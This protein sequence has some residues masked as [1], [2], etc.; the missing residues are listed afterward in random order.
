MTNTDSIS[1]KAHAILDAAETHMRRG[2]FDAVSFRDLATEVG[3]KSASV[4]YH[5]PQKGDLGEA[6]VHRYTAR[7]LE[8]LGDPAALKMSTATERLMQLYT[9]ALLEGDSVCL[10]CILGA[11][12]QTL[13]EAVTK[14]VQIYFS[15]IINWL[16][17]AYSNTAAGQ[18]HSPLAAYVVSALQGAMT[19]AIATG[20]HTHFRTTTE[21]I[22]L[23]VRTEETK[24]NLFG[25]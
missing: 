3:I 13:P 25:R 24:L 5:F 10:C 7:V 12:A 14:A 2:G 11:E 19:L 4:H 9:T 17:E 16:T 18:D 21:M 1:P 23:H 15:S 20:N 6:L 8:F 22:E